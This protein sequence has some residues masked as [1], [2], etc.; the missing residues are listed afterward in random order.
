MWPGSPGHQPY[1][2]SGRGTHE[3]AAN[4]SINEELAWYSLH[5]PITALDPLG[6]HYR[7]W[8]FRF[9]M[10]NQSYNSCVYI[11]RICIHLWSLF[12]HEMVLLSLPFPCG[13]FHF[14]RSVPPPCFKSNTFCIL[15][16]LWFLQSRFVCRFR[17]ARYLHPSIFSAGWEWGV[18]RLMIISAKPAS[19]RR[20]KSHWWQTPS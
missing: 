5:D 6:P 18:G 1:N 8:L 11:W 17:W 12:F 9:S 19:N 10:Q 15:N 4:N 2:S 13:T 16:L 7:F 3:N 20:T 14:C